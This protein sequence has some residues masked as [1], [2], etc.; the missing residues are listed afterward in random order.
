MQVVFHNFSHLFG[1]AAVV[2]VSYTHLQ[3]Q[4][5]ATIFGKQAMAGMLSIINASEEDYKKLTSATRNYSGTAKE[6]AEIMEDNLQGGLTKLK[7]A[8][9]GVGIQIF[10]LLLPHLQKMCIRDR[11]KGELVK[12]PYLESTAMYK[13]GKTLYEL[14]DDGLLHEQ[15]RK[16]VPAIGEFP[17]HKHQEKAIELSISKNKNIIV[18]TGTGSGKTEC[19]LIPILNYLVEQNVKGLLSP[20]VRALILYPMNALA[21]DQLKRLRKLLKDYPDITFGLSLIHI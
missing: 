1:G 2:P 16:L 3:A 15:F 19:F 11:S 9:E 20:G 6:M 10:E 17:L 21:N 4:E 8:L 14:I 7:S 18:A 12:G 5:A 13:S